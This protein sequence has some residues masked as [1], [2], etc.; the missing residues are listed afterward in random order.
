MA[1]RARSSRRLTLAA[2]AVLSLLLCSCSGQDDPVA[3]QTPSATTSAA[4][5]SAP[6][7]SSTVPLSAEDQAVLEAT[8]AVREFRATVD[9]INADPNSDADTLHDVTTG[10]AYLEQVRMAVQ[11]KARGRTQTGTVRVID[12]T[13]VSI[14]LTTDTALKP[15]K[16][17]TVVLDSCIDVSGTDVLDADGKSV[18]VAT[19]Q[20]QV[21]ERL[22]VVHFDFGWRVHRI[23]SKGEPCR[24]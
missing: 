7:T 2:G 15:P 8:E 6:P 21:N 9:R 14:D 1:A 11:A 22:D 16:Y 10:D 3:E 4:A 23:E 18:V 17:P 19:R 5:T 13:P 20:D 12:A 24:P